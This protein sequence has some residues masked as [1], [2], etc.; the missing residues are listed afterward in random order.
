MV[1]VER[2][3]INLTNDG[4]RFWW[5]DTRLSELVSLPSRSSTSEVLFDF[6]PSSSTQ[7]HPQLVFPYPTVFLPVPYHLDLSLI[8]L[9][10]T[11]IPRSR[12]LRHLTIQLPSHPD[13]SCVPGGVDSGMEVDHQESIRPETATAKIQPDGL[14]LYVS[15]ASYEPGTSPL[16]SW[17]PIKAYEDKSGSPLD[18]F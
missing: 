13:M 1:T 12:S 14:L 10:S 9:L 8:S 17:V 3:S 4:Y 18:L 2:S 15:Q 5:R 16:S 11:I 6:T 7:S